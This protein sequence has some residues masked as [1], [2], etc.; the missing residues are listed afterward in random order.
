M[1][2][3]LFYCF[4]FYGN[5]KKW[6]ARLSERK[7][8]RDGNV[9]G[10]SDGGNDTERKHHFN[11]SFRILVVFWAN[12]LNGSFHILSFDVIVSYILIIG[13]VIWIVT[14]NCYYNL[15]RCFIMRHCF[16]LNL[17]PEDPAFSP[18][19]PNEIYCAAANFRIFLFRFFTD[20][21]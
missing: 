19:W 13:L 15:W 16:Y 11:L 17:I 10:S 5:G 6:W 20:W 12:M 14:L 18:G 9:F 7:I 1:T 2:L 8:K 4:N 3:T 21:P